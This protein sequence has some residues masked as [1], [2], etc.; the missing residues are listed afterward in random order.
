M[1]M[2]PN[3]SGTI[4]FEID[5]ATWGS[6]PNGTASATGGQ[7]DQNGVGYW[8]TDRTA[9]E[10]KNVYIDFGLPY[11]GI[12]VPITVRVGAQPFVLRPNMVLAS[13][14]MGVTAAA[15]IDPVAI[16]FYYGKMV[17][18]LLWDSDDSDMY[19]LN[20]N[21]KLGTFTLGA[22]GLWY[23]MNTYPTWVASAWVT[24]GNT[25][26]PSG[27]YPVIN[28]TMKANMW[29]WGAYLDGKAGPVDLNFD[30][31]YDYGRV[32]RKLVST[33]TFYPDVLYRGYA[34]RLKIDFPWEKFNFGVVGMYAS[35][36]DA[37]ETSVTG[38]PGT[39]VAN[40]AGGTGPLAT[41]FSK[42][43]TGY[44]TPIGSEQ[45]T[46]NNE[47]VVVYG[48]EAGASGSIG[49]A[50]NANY[51]QLS[52]GGFGGTWFAKLYGSA[53]LTPWYKVTVNALY[54][55]DTTAHGNTLGSAVKYNLT[56]IPILKDSSTIG[57][58][59]DLINEIW[60]Y[61]NLRFMFGGGYLIKGGALDVSR[62]VQPVPGAIPIYQNS[63]PANP[64]AIRTRLIYTF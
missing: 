33:P 11:F 29:W 38:L 39:T 18:G 26:L 23:N 47:S 56:P 52:R 4:M 7:R 31:V 32:S 28:G 36:S 19:G 6:G 2:G 48:T 34:T 55:G 8:T 10:V 15:K 3:L 46:A 14:G 53:K 27:L 40:G 17:E 50:K 57:W 13:D 20:A 30:F 21:V 22:Y 5:S 64:W 35:G 54:I 12:P 59:F 43:V 25:T 41:K 37:S 63:G 62:N 58:E 61:N 24:G 60:I 42:K 9:V 44:V 45:D 16:S 1:V 51:A 49:I